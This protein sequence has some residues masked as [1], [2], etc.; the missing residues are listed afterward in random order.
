M[1]IFQQHSESIPEE[2]E[3]L[4]DEPEPDYDDGF[5]P[6]PRRNGKDVIAVPK[7]NAPPA[8]PLPPASVIFG[9]NNNKVRRFSAPAGG[10]VSQTGPKINGV[11]KKSRFEI[12]YVTTKS[13]NN[14]YYA[15][16]TIEETNEEDTESH[17]IK[18]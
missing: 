18:F 5:A 6:A 12:P 13:Y 8:P 2:P 16:T 3:S 1:L 11:H 15:P 17:V 10:F 14:N 4:N 9:N 7:G